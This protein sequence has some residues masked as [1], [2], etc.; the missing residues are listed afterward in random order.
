VR[1]SV[2]AGMT[3]VTRAPIGATVRHPELFDMLKSA[4]AEGLA[5]AHAKGIRVPTSTV[6]DVA[7]A[8]RALPADAKSSML[9]DLERGRR[10]ELPWL[11]GAVQRLG[12]EVGIPTPIHSFINAVLTPHVNGTP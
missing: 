1:L 10:L 3:S 5:V 6:E 9:E 11:S 12:R 8:Y 2:F 7:R 4:V